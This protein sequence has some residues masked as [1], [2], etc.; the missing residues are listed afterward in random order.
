MA[1][2]QDRQTLRPNS[3]GSRWFRGH[4]PPELD[5]PKVSALGVTVVLPLS[6]SSEVEETGP[7]KALQTQSYWP[8]SAFLVHLTKSHSN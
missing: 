4:T 6:S 2:R 3:R 7:G 8:L 1:W 5:L